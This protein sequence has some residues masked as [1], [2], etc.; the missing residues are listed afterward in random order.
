M[1]AQPGRRI[2]VLLSEGSSTSAREAVT[3]LALAGHTVEVCDPDPFCLTRFSRLVSKFHRCP[4]LRAD[5]HGYLGFVL[6]L[7]SRRHFDVLLP[8]HEQGFLFARERERLEPYVAIALPSF[9]SYRTAHRKASFGRLLSE[10]GLAQPETRIVA[11][12]GELLAVEQFPV[13]VKTSI[14]TASRGVWTVRDRQE[15]RAAAEALAGADAFA[16]E[17]L[18]QMFV[19]G[20][21]EHAQGVFCRGRLVAIHACRQVARGAG[22]GDAIKQ[23]IHRPVVRA[24]LARIGERL[25]W[26]GAL[27][28]DYIIPSDGLDV[29]L[30]IDCNP[31]LVEPM[32]AL[33]SGNDLADLLVRVS[34]GA[35]PAGVAEGRAGTRSHQGLQALLG[36]A[37]AGGSRRDIW[38]ECRRLATGRGPYAGS[39]EE[40]TP[41]RL[42]WPSVIPELIVALR[43]LARPQAAHDLPGRFGSHL[44]DIATARAIAEPHDQPP[45]G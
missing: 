9:E 22:G 24:H 26:H 25:A 33:L 2:R 13:V 38:R 34:L 21:V 16:D 41:V 20:A 27:S 18:V 28:V 42:D 14:G 4:G 12:A 10:L 32:S 37:L 45:G 43:L 19:E 35:D 7:I 31:R 5:P 6:A 40:L 8:I 11:D 29:P 17:V 30:Y 44:V 3:A 1:R 23:S 39:V 15:L 36:C